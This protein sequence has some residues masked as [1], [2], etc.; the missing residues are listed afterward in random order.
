MMQKSSPR[1]HRETGITYLSTY[2]PRECGLATFTKHLVDALDSLNWFGSQSIIA[3]NEKAHT[4]NYDKRV[5]W[6]IMQ[7]YDE[8]YARAAYLVNSSKT[9][10]VSIQHEFGIYGGDWGEY[11]NQFIDSIEKPVVT[12]LHTVESGFPQKAQDILKKIVSISASLV[13]MAGAARQMLHEYNVPLDKIHVIQHGCPDIPFVSSDSVKPSLGLGGRVVLST[14]GLMS[15]SKGIEYAIRALPPIV[16]KDPRILYLVIGETHPVVRRNEGETYRRS[17][18]ALVEELKLGEHVRFHNRYL[19]ERELI[20]YLQ[21][22]DIY[23]MPYTSPSQASSGT[24][25]YAVGSG[26]A[27]IATPFIHAKEVLAEGRGLFCEFNDSE[28][29]TENIKKLLM[30]TEL[31]GSIERKAYAFSRGFVW[32]KVAKKYASLFQQA[33]RRQRDRLHG[34]PAH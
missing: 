32:Q 15:S 3:V 22:T 30:D 14:F 25:V 12:T 24:L 20:R 19:A 7:D 26:T 6:Q 33:V 31:K 17:L 5:R 4:Y 27:V 8:D 13:V 23:L 2:P 16:A 1:P 29:I 18:M 11:I 28:S 9:S 21:A 10:V 34:A